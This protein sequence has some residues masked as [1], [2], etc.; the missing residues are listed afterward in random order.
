MGRRRGNGEGSIFQRSDGRWC[1]QVNVGWKD[2]KPVRRFVYGK[3]RREVQ[4]RLTGTLHAFQTGALPAGKAHTVAEFLTSWVEQV[5][6]GP[7]TRPAYR[8]WVRHICSVLG[9]YRVDRLTVPQVN[10]LL[11]E[12]GK[13]MKPQSVAHMRGVLRNALNDGMRWGLVTKNVAALADPPSVEEYEATV[14]DADAARAFLVA[15]EQDR[16]SA[17]YVL[18]ILGLREGEL[19]GLRWE[20]VDFDTRAIHIR[21]ALKRIPGEGLQVLDTKTRKSKRD[22]TVPHFIVRALR[23]HR[24]RQTEERLLAGRRWRDSGLVFTTLVGGPLNAT[25][26]VR[27]SFHKVCDRAGV[28]Y[29]TR[30]RKGLRVHDLRHSAASILLAMGV[31]KRVVKDVLGHTSDASYGRYTHVPSSMLS[32]A[33][34]RLDEALGR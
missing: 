31:D 22:L 9:R 29:G 19:L 27:R 24:I 3:S 13:V 23:A 7:T 5:K 15:A 20:D 12:K 8:L 33:A 25:N 21:K 16:L 10:D 18:A 14:L 26:V 2:G 34:D 4:E 28:P 1:A 11:M 32:D 6:V 17:F 30:E